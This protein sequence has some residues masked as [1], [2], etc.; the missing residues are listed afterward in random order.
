MKKDIKDYIHLYLGCDVIVH[1]TIRATLNLL[2]H[3][4]RI[5][6]VKLSEAF[7]QTL[8]VMYNEVKL[9]LRPLS[10]MTEEE[11]VE[12]FQVGE[13][14]WRQRHLEFTSE[15]FIK[16]LSKGFDLFGLIEAGLA[17]DKTKIAA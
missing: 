13:S 15:Q 6:V 5:A 8:S 4:H 14:D 12:I 1:N 3:D 9:P 17:I 10:D 2:N 11:K 16:L 7:G